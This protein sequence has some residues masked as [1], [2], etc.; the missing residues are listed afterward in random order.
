MTHQLSLPQTWLWLT[1]FSISMGFL[2][3]AVVV[4]LR[5]LYYPTGFAFPL[6]PIKSGV[7]VTELLREAATLLMLLSVGVLVGRTA[8]QRFSFAI[9]S[10]AVWDLCYYLFLKL[11]LDWPESL[12]TW[13]ILF[14]IPVP[15]VGPV[16][17]PCLV[18]LTMTGLAVAAVR[19]ERRG[20]VLRFT[21]A[22]QGLW[23]AGS[24]LILGSFMGDYVAYV[25]AHHGELW[26]ASGGKA[27][28]SE[29]PAYMP[30]SFNWWL[31]GL[32]EAGLLAGIACWVWQTIA[33]K[34]AVR[35]RNRP[36]RTLDGPN[37]GGFSDYLN[38][39]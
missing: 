22:A 20:Y 27:P 34:P 4:Y 13:D 24:L 39:L 11:L 3:S 30:Q 19:L 8:V 16:L 18:A 2:E 15:W 1:A 10:F 9:Y 12:F 33:Q 29:A 35:L 5:E 21:A 14:L 25:Q 32:G 7:A 36:K 31:F 26:T 17:A 6:V 38:G 37:A 23:W 28:F